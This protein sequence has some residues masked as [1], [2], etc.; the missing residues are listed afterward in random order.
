MRNKCSPCTS[1]REKK[2]L[3][4]NSVTNYSVLFHALS[5]NM[6]R[7]RALRLNAQ[8][9]LY[10]YLFSYLYY[11][12]RIVVQKISAARQSKALLH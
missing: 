11:S 4:S 9:S 12:Q 7:G 3:E 1:T 8:M 5:E 2:G 10:S 6:G